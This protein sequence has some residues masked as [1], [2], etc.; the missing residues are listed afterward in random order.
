MSAQ[1]RM[2]CLKAENKSIDG[3]YVRVITNCFII[4]S[5]CKSNDG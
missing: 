1:V 5:Q 3:Q 4:F 2:N